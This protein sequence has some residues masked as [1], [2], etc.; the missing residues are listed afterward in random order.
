MVVVLLPCAFYMVANVASLPS[1]VL[2]PA[3][4]P[5]FTL[6]VMTSINLTSKMEKRK[7]K[8][9]WLEVIDY[10]SSGA[11]NNWEVMKELKELEMSPLIERRFGDYGSRILATTIPTHFLQSL[12]FQA[13]MQEAANCFF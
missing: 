7:K 13:S 4:P 9:A 3:L 8:G 5:P 6:W 2:P 10:V 12:F 1:L 11:G